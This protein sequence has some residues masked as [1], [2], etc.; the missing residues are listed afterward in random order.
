MEPIKNHT[1]QSLFETQNQYV[2]QKANETH[3][4]LVNQARSEN[5]DMSVI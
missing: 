4:R 1:N 3:I 5:Q 2:N